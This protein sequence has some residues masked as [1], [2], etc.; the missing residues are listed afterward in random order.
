MIQSDRNLTF[1]AGLLAIGHGLNHFVQVPQLINP[2]LPAQPGSPNTAVVQAYA[3]LLS[4]GKSDVEAIENQRRDGFLQH[5]LS[6]PSVT[7]APA[8]LPQHKMESD[9]DWLN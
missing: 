5:A 2:A 9:S 3:C 1:D 6:L 7:S 4:I 8:T